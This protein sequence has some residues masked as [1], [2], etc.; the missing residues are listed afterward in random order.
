MKRLLMALSIAALGMFYSGAANAAFTQTTTATMN[1]NMT[2]TASCSASTTAMNFGTGTGATA[3][4]ST[5]TITVTCSN[6]APYRVDIDKGTANLGPGVD[7]TTRTMNDG[8]SNTLIYGL[9]KTN[10]YLAADE[11]G[12]NGTTYCTT[13]VPAV[14]GLTGTGNGMA[15]VLTVYGETQTSMALPLPGAYSD[16]LTVTVNY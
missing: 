9:Y 11:W 2:V 3:L 16:T 14:T 8:A 5:S 15:Q 7:V 4:Q 12:D 13:C 10:S 6:G 1:V